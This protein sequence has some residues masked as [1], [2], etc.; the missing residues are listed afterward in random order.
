VA[1]RDSR[2]PLD[3][4]PGDGPVEDSQA[5][6]RSAIFNDPDVIKHL[7]GLRDLR[8]KH[9]PRGMLYLRELHNP[10]LMEQFTPSYLDQRIAVIR[11]RLEGDGRYWRNMIPVDD[12]GAGYGRDRGAYPSMDPETIKLA[13]ADFVRRLTGHQHPDLDLTV[14]LPS[15]V[16]QNRRRLRKLATS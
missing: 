2:F 1:G 11:E 7:L 12:K 4:A 10:V 16:R 13:V 8:D 3:L 15:K 5:Y 14:T 6:T 9:G